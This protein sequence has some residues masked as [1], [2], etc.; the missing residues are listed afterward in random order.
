MLLALWNN[1]LYLGHVLTR[2]FHFSREGP[3]SVVNFRLAWPD[4]ERAQ[5]KRRI[6]DGFSQPVSSELGGPADGGDFDL[7]SLTPTVIG[8]TEGV[9]PK[10]PFWGV[11]DP[12]QR[13]VSS[14][15]SSAPFDLK[16]S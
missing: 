3:C 14:S 6:S 2:Q 12:L 11:F 7:P 5:S 15:L 4:P 1:A 16:P 13:I 8:S 10:F 9:D